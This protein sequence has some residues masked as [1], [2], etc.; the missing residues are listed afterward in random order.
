AA[1]RAEDFDIFAG[2]AVSLEFSDNGFELVAHALGGGA[3]LLLLELLLEDVIGRSG[4]WRGHQRG[5]K[6]EPGQARAKEMDGFYHKY[7]FPETWTADDSGKF[8]R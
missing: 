2:N 8:M 7:W 6:E 3:E 1:D 5:D 4:R